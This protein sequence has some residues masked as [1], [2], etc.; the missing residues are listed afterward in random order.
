[1]KKIVIVAFIMACL[2]LLCS[3]GNMSIGLG[4]FTFTTVHVQYGNECKDFTVEK[5]HNDDMGIEVLTKE[6]GAMFLSEGTYILFENE[7]ELC[8]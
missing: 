7:C 8:K 4:S 5:W 6:A 3:C 1:M 2:I